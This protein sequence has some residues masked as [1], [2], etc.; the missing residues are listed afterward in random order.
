M[1]AVLQRVKKAE[2]QVKDKKIS[3][4]GAG[5]LILLGVRKGDTEKQ[6]EDLA[7]MCVNLRIFEDSNGKFN[8]SLKDVN[9][10][11][12][13]VSQFTLL[14]DTSRG[15]RPSFTDAEEPDKAKR[16]YEFF[17]DRLKNFGITTKSGVFGERMLVSLENNGP[18]TIILEV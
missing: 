18:V 9:G 3:E 10:E 17:I 13:V 16:L 5:L 11:A 2:V 8:L 12:L 7:Q 6:T 1:K 4:I 15:R 14:A